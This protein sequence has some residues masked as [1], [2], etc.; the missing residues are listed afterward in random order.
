MLDK[1]KKNKL[2]DGAFYGIRPCSATLVAIAMLDVLILSVFSGSRAISIGSLTI[3][4]IPE[5]VNIVGIIF[6]AALIPFIVK[7]K[8]VHPIV[9]IAI[10]AV[11]GILF[12]M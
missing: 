6:F 8:K 9:F 2:V 7:F 5:S 3:S 1:F 4:G 11:I 10:G 12:K